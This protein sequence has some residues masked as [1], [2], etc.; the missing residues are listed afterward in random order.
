[1]LAR[2]RNFFEQQVLFFTAF[3]AGI[4]MAAAVFEMVVEAETTL[5]IA[6]T[7][8]AFLGGAIIFTLAD[9]IAEKKVVELV[10]YWVSD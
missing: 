5:G 8:L 9:V 10:S 4:L 6:I 3:G 2:K 1:L 7:L